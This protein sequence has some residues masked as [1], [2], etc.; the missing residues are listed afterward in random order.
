MILRRLLLHISEPHYMGMIKLTSKGSCEDFMYG[1][2]N[3]WHIIGLTKMEAAPTENILHRLP[4][5][6]QLSCSG[7]LHPAD[8]HPESC[9]CLSHFIHTVMEAC[10]ISALNFLFPPEGSI[11]PGWGAGYR[12]RRAA[13][14]RR[15]PPACHSGLT[16]PARA[17][18]SG[19]ACI[20]AFSTGSWW[21]ETPRGQGRAES[22][23]PS[24]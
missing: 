22:L 19:D 24:P 2:H 21:P 11:P 14:P 16:P 12:G 13:E 23:S 15:S 9:L 8:Q 7:G 10:G 18:C 3:A 6:T 20:G 17:C 5:E 4:L 1:E